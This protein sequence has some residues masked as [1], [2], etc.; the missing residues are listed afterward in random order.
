MTNRQ[1]FGQLAPLRWEWTASDAAVAIGAG[2]K[3]E[4]LRTGGSPGH[5]VAYALSLGA[6]NLARLIETDDPVLARAMCDRHHAAHV[7]QFFSKP[8]TDGT[9]P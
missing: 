3:Y 1:T 6:T 5:W 9:K 8:T 7:A 2:V 4:L